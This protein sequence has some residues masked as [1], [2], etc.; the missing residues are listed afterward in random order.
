MNKWLVRGLVVL[1]VTVVALAGLA[2]Y[3]FWALLSP[4]GVEQTVRPP[5]SAY[6]PQPMQEAGMPA[7]PGPV[8]VAPVAPVPPPVKVYKPE[9]LSPDRQA[10]MQKYNEALQALRAKHRETMQELRGVS[11]GG[12]GNNR[13]A[14]QTWREERKRLNQEH[15]QEIEALRA[16][17][18]VTPEEEKA[19]SYLELEQRRAAAMARLKEKQ[20]AQPE[21][22]T[23][24]MGE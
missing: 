1:V 18:G 12:G 15:S 2:A 13:E 7:A 10:V 9:P 6:P 16:Q 11:R 23:G 24:A 3:N 17:Y 4:P 14:K 22:E 19:F 21:E 20:G 5:M 8:A